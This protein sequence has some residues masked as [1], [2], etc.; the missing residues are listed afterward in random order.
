MS[1]G[2]VLAVIATASACGSSGSAAKPV[3]SLTSSASLTAP[4]A[5]GGKPVTASPVLSRFDPP[6]KFGATGS[7]LPQEANYGSSTL[8]GLPVTLSKDVA[9]IAA[10]DSV[11]AVNLTTGVTL[12][13]VSPTNKPLNGDT[14]SRARGPLVQSTANGG[15]TVYCAFAVTVAGQGTTPSQP[16]VELWAIDAASGKPSWSATVPQQDQSKQYVNAQS[17]SIVGADGTAVIVA[18]TDEAG[19]ATYAISP[20][21]HRQLWAKDKFVPDVLVDG[22]VVGVNRPD[23]VAGYAMAFDAATGAQRWAWTDR[24]YTSADFTAAGPDMVAFTGADY[25]S[26]KPV[27]E[28][29][30]PKTGKTA[31]NADLVGG[32]VF[33]QLSTAVCTS[34]AGAGQQVQAFDATTGHLL[35]QLPDSGSNRVAPRVTAVWHGAVYGTTSNGPVVLDAHSGADKQDSPGVAPS[36]VDEYYGIGLNDSQKVAAFPA[37]G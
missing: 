19:S 29:S 17:A 7:A 16:A 24:E 8:G 23:G 30:D 36:V 27:S 5:G 2:C 9:Y 33:D 12:W 15:S 1:T 10:A 3:P 13:R 18:E 28:F 37:A 32:C 6:T 22:S 11:Q 20:T 31:A 35:W 14:Q 34:N 4:N 25:S 26:L 21:T